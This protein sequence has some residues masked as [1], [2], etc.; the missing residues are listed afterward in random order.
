M[1]N[2]NIKRPRVSIGI[3]VYNGENYIIPALDSILDQ[4]Y[5]NFEVI[6]SDNASSDGTADICRQYASQDHR[7]HYYR[8]EINLGAAQNYNRVFNLSRGEYFKWVAHDDVHASHFLSR[9]VK[10]LDLD[11]TIALCYTKTNIV[12]EDGK[13]LLNYIVEVNTASKKPYQ[14]F[15][16]MINIEHWCYQIF[17]LF[18]SDALRMTRLIEPYTD[19]DRVLLAEVCLIGRVVEIPEYLFFRREHPGT[20]TN[21]YLKDNER[22][23]WYDPRL[24]GQK[25]SPTWLKLKGYFTSISRAPLSLSERMLSY[26]QLASVL[27]NKAMLRLKRKLTKSHNRNHIAIPVDGVR[28]K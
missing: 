10:L 4:T 14:R 7:I 21:V 25:L 5:T 18:R 20:S 8:N 16:N 13:P 26:Y 12:D 3:P 24:A 28:W 23:V 1:E 2:V 11:P 19:S 6:I 15:R 22:M 17:G 27:L 9:C